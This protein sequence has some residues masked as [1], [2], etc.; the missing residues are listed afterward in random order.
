VKKDFPIE[1]GFLDVIAIKRAQAKIAIPRNPPQ[2]IEGFPGGEK[3][4]NSSF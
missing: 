4:G 3:N 2:G 1:E